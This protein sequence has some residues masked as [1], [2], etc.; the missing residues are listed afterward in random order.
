MYGYYSRAVCNQERV[1][2]ARVRQIETE[3]GDIQCLALQQLG[4]MDSFIKETY[5]EETTACSASIRQKI[6]AWISSMKDLRQE[7]LPSQFIPISSA[8]REMRVSMND[9]LVQLI[10]QSILR[11][12]NILFVHFLSTFKSF[13]LISKY[14]Q[15]CQY[16]I[17]KKKKTLC[18]T[19]NW[20][21]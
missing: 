15:K 11:I 2:M 16:N 6:K 21:N 17:K 3:D 8:I 1:I 13:N 9:Y 20:G 18:N 12:P 10:E 7:F 4:Y 14:T 19:L 5:C